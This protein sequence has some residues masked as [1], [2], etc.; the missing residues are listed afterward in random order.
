MAISLKQV[1][2]ETKQKYQ[3][4]LVAGEAGLER[5]INWVY[6][7]ESLE[8]IEFLKGG[9]LII[10]TGFI[11]QQDEALLQL[12]KALKEKR[13]CGLILNIG[14]YIE[15]AS[16]PVRQ[17][18][19]LQK[20]P[21]F[22]MPWEVHIMELS[23]DYYKRI[24]QSERISQELSEAFHVIL[25]HPDMMRA[26]KN[27]LEQNGFLEVQS[28]YCVLLHGIAVADESLN[29]AIGYMMRKIPCYC[30]L[31]Y[32]GDYLLIVA[33]EEEQ[34]LKSLAYKLQSRCEEI[35]GQG[36][37]Y[38]GIGSKAE[39]LQ[40]L[41]YS[42]KN[43]R[44]ALQ[45][46]MYFEE[47]VT[48]F[49]EMGMYQILMSV[50]QEAVLKRYYERYLAPLVIYDQ[51][52]QMDLIETLRLYLKYDGSVSRVAKELFVHRNTVNHRMSRIKEIL[53]LQLEISKECFNVQT[54]LYIYDLYA[55]R[56]EV[57]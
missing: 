29:E 42:L 27:V 41:M 55:L 13:C 38:V 46:G 4:E 2:L 30:L 10:T 3:L 25:E 43:A 19:E 26:Y 7:M 53:Q 20:L 48:V 33:A 15:S 21:L 17:Y 36:T 23:R 11:F 14:K 16:L 28:Y 45:K 5:M 18:C 1:Y 56:K 57:Q 49:E 8:D 9:E 40:L 12:L 6:R 54:A 35:N 50:S 47:K 37:I 32:E 51:I 31:E 39:N 22:E 52:H 34:L 24:D 44:A